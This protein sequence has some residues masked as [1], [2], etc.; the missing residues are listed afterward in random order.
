[1]FYEHYTYG[2]VQKKTPNNIK[3]NDPINNKYKGSTPVG[4]RY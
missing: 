3:S 1:M 4:G 2:R